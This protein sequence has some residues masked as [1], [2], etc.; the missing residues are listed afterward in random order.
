[1]A[2]GIA[3]FEIAKTEQDFKDAI[4]EFEKAVNTAPWLERDTGTSALFMTR[5]ASLM[6]R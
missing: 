1:M 4:A 5:L 2:R 3:A 6:P